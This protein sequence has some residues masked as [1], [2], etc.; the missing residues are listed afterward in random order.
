MIREFVVADHGAVGLAAR[1]AKLGFVDLLEDLALIELDGL[2]Q[3]LE[4]L[5]LRDVHDADLELG[6]GLGVHHEV[7]HAPPRA[8]QLLEVGVV[9]DR[10]QLL[11][12]RRV[13]RRDRL[14][15]RLRDAL[16]ERHRSL[17]RL[18]DEGADEFVATRLLHGAGHHAGDLVQQAS[19]CCG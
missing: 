16:V 1:R 17:E 3:I 18:F 9:H 4:Q 6:A 10:G 12:H 15:D 7:M 2:V 14:I 19:R 8:F 13:D 5:P 11:R